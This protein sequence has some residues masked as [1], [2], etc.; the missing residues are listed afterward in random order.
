[1][2]FQTPFGDASHRYWRQ[3]FIPDGGFMVETGCISTATDT[4][5]YVETHMTECIAVVLDTA[6]GSDCID[7]IPDVSYGDESSG[8]IIASLTGAMANGYTNYVAVGY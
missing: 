1:M 8:H 7:G 3:V 6:D 2:A 5:F 4:T